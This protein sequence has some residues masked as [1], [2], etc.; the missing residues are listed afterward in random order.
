MLGSTASLRMLRRR[1]QNNEDEGERY[2]IS[3]RLVKSSH[4][5]NDAAAVDQRDYDAKARSSK[6]RPNGRRSPRH[7]R[8]FVQAIALAM[9]ILCFVVLSSF[10]G[11]VVGD[12]AMVRRSLFVKDDRPSTRRIRIRLSSQWRSQW[13]VAA[14]QTPPV[15]NSNQHHDEQ[16][17]SPEFPKVY[18]QA[19]DGAPRTIN[20]DSDGNLY[21]QERDEQLE[22]MNVH[23]D[24]LDPYYANREDM[25]PRDPCRRNQMRSLRFQN[26]NTFHEL[27][28]E[29]PPMGSTHLQPYNVTYR[30]KGSFRVSWHFHAI[31][32][33]D[34][35]DHGDEFV[36]KVLLYGSDFDYQVMT[37]MNNEAVVM[38]RLSGSP[39]IV[40][41]HGNCGASIMAE[42]ME[43][44]LT[45]E[46]VPG[47][48]INYS[49]YGYMKQSDLD[50]VQSLDVAPQNDLS[51]QQKLEYAIA[52]A[53]AIADIHGFGGG[54]IVHG[55]I[56]PVQFLKNKAGSIK[57]NDF[58]NGQVLTFD[59]AKGEYCEEWRCYGGTYR[60]PEELLCDE[61]YSNEA[62]D[63]W[64]MGNNIYSLLTGLWPYYEFG[65]K[66]DRNVIQR[67]RQC[68]TPTVDSRYRNRS[69]IE[70][71]LVRIMEQTWECDYKKRLSIFGVVQQLYELQ[72][73]AKRK[74]LVK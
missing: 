20:R 18:N 17:S 73:Q 28:L 3:D 72:E 24:G 50:A 59:K 48:E 49:N 37:E 55:D 14:I 56:H 74:G 15:F 7:Q 63:V 70:G 61:T 65:S 4:G 19:G 69:F 43:Y 26:C 41:M 6:Q 71:G 30:G 64:P 67:I 39:R 25:D 16:Q 1:C 29:R 66:Q 33:E 36:L 45:K 60:P 5:N 10:H 52:M 46:L 12:A 51:V 21:E 27:S 42:H 58:N 31:S 34:D 47:S 9:L 62:V 2:E 23:P 53:E 68:E 35:H 11:D 32:N 40:D 22:E 44:E 38:E 13:L 57:L 8:I 54:V